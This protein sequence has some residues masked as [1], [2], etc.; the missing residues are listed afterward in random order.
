MRVP[1]RIAPVGPMS[2][3]L[4]ALAPEDS[5]ESGPAPR[6]GLPEARCRLGRGGYTCACALARRQCAHVP[7]NVL[8]TRS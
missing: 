2:E 7:Q 5:T 8:R 1:H 3:I 4:R 6:A